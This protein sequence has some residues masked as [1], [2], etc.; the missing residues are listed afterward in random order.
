MYEA[1]E[2]LGL[3]FSAVQKRDGGLL[4]MSNKKSELEQK[5]YTQKIDGKL[6]SLKIAANTFSLEGA[7]LK[8][9]PSVRGDLTYLKTKDFI[10]GS[11]SESIAILDPKLR[12]ISLT[13]EPYLPLPSLSKKSTDP[14]PG[15]LAKVFKSTVMDKSFNVVSD[16]TDYSNGEAGEWIHQKLGEKDWALA[17]IK[18]KLVLPKA[19]PWKGRYGTK[20]ESAKIDTIYIWLAFLTHNGKD[21]WYIGNSSGDPCGTD[22]KSS[23]Q[24]TIE[25]GAATIGNI[26]EPKYGFRISN[27]EKNLVYSFGDPD[28]V[29]YLNF[30]KDMVVISNESYR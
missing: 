14:L 4:F 8:N 17:Q 10:S 12:V 7:T 16:I 19:V 21:F 5:K 15:N 27:S 22:L 20:S 23:V 26:L 6:G 13:D 9:Y 3:T 18:M 1:P 30:G 24:S 29:Y 25:N 2:S 28:I 11:P